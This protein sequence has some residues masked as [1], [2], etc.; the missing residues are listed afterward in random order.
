MHYKEWCSA[1]A[2]VVSHSPPCSAIGSVSRRT[3][4]GRSS[5]CFSRSSCVCGMAVRQALAVVVVVMLVM[6]TG[7]GAAA[8]YEVGDKAGWTIMGSP[9]YNAWAVSKKFQ[10]G[11]SI[12]ESSPPTCSLVSLLPTIMFCFPVA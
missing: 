6:C 1:A 8:V 9:N 2:S 12:G 3:G 10:L 4:R 11:D 7:V 5:P